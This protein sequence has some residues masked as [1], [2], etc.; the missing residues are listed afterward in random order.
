[1]RLRLR[2][3]PVLFILALAVPAAGQNGAERVHT[4]EVAPGVTFTEIVRPAVPLV[5]TALKV[6]PGLARVG[7]FVA[8]DRINSSTREVV[9]SAAARSGAVA[10][11]NGDFFPWTADPLGFTVV[12]GR[13]VSEPYPDRPAVALRRDGQVLMGIVRMAL[14]LHFDNFRMLKV[15]GVDRPFQGG[16]LIVYDRYFG[17]G[18]SAGRD[19]A[20]MVLRVDWPGLLEK[21]HA[22]AE[23]LA[24]L[25]EGADSPIPEDGVVVVAKGPR[26][27]EL[28]NAARGQSRVRLRLALQDEDGRSWLGVS[29]AVGGEP[30]LIK[31]GEFSKRTDR[32]GLDAATP[33][34]SNRHPRTAV[35]VTRDGHFLL[36]VVDGRQITSRGATLREMAQLMMELGC[37]EA[38]NLDGGGSST[39]VVRG[40]VVNSPSDGQQ[41][42]V[43]SGLLVRS[44]EEARAAPEPLTVAPS[45]V[46]MTAGQRQKFTVLR[47]DGTPLD[48]GQTGSVIWGTRNGGGFVEQDGVFVALRSGSPVVGAWIAGSSAEAKV[49]VSPAGPGRVRVS[50]AQ[51]ASLEAGS[52]AL[53]ISVTDTLGNAVPFPKLRVTVEGGTVDQP[54][55]DGGP[56]GIARVTVTWDASVPVAGRKVRAESNGA[57]GS[58][59]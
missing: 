23:I 13:L 25:E 31:K 14:T 47:A 41:R 49:S 34:A 37:V 8:N 54:E 52:T 55:P 12:D 19:C 26:R 24:L 59:P 50:L 46:Q 2:F 40:L 27:A 38:I 56:D 22:D 29:E 53:V 10:A 3:L 33:F 35:G 20:E 44:A 6:D 15:D 48:A 16:E 58:L 1:V 4:R 42:A 51:G 18:T 9:S 39:L 11:T 28:L 21:G 43:A 5:V 30:W 57:S 7:A 32:H 45:P 17:P 36:V